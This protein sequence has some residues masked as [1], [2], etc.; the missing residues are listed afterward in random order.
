MRTASL[1]VQMVVRVAWLVQ[2]V[3]GLLFWSGN[4]LAL[5]PV[6]MLIGLL[7]V[8]G[9]WTQTVLGARAGAPLP[10][11]V[12]GA[13]WGLVVPVFGVLQ[14]GLLPGGAH[15]IVQAVHLLFGIVAI[16]LAETLSARVVGRRR[17]PWQG[18]APGGN[19]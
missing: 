3:L 17:G 5:V 7:I 16:A 11:V 10:L 13:L 4:Q 12:A 2:L 14:G 15:W 1:A 18:W 8:L 6:H 9:L 19:R